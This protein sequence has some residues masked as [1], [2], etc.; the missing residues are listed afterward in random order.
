[1]PSDKGFKH[2]VVDEEG[3]ALLAEYRE[4]MRSSNQELDDIH[5][6]FSA[7]SKKSREEGQ[8]K[9]YGLWKRLSASVGLDPD[10]S[11]NDGQYGVETRYL[12]SGFGA[13]TYS[14]AALNPIEA[15][16]ALQQLDDKVD[17]GEEISSILPP[18]G[19]KLN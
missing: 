19:T 12:E 4:V 10:K 16:M 18:K 3:R 2:F 15:L 5:A 17:E 14:Q 9:L 7:R 1:M 11:W 13:L 8:A 6:E